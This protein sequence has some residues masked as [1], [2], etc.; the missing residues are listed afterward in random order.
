MAGQ[1]LAWLLLA[2]EV[3]AHTPGH[4]HKGGNSFARNGRLNS[5]ALWPTIAHDA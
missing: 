3:L 2:I 5:E 4:E 1:A